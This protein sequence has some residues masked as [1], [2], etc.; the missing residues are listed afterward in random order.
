MNYKEILEW[1]NKRQ[2][3]TAKGRTVRNGYNH[4]ILNK[5]RISDD[6]FQQIF[7][8]LITN[9]ALDC[10]EKN[11]YSVDPVKKERKKWSLETGILIRKSYLLGN[12]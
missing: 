9:C 8:S 3:K 1:L 6:K 10:F 5:K 7:P 4:S 11:S 2:I 12:G